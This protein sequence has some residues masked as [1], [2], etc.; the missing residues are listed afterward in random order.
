MIILCEL[1]NQ[2]VMIDIAINA[3]YLI[4]K[5]LIE[6]D[7]SREFVNYVI[8]KLSKE[9]LKLENKDDYIL[10]ID[11]YSEIRLIELFGISKVND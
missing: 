10:S 8:P 2:E 1:K 9:F 11:R 5:G 4:S 3:G 7:N 6:I